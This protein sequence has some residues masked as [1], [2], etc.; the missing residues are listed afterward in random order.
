[1]VKPIQGPKLYEPPVGQQ[2]HI[3][4]DALTEQLTAEL[5]KFYPNTSIVYSL[6]KK[7]ANPD[8]TNIAGSTALVLAATVGDLKLA[9]LVI[10][11]V[12]NINTKT[13]DGGT[14]LIRAL[15]N[16]NYLV[17]MLIAKKLVEKF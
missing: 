9:T 3:S 11:K 5:N 16:K 2:D 7:G 13:M 10:E 6:I 14:A 8:A 15:E 12:A 17:A 4:N 1:M